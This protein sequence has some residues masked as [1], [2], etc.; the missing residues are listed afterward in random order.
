LRAEKGWTQEEA[1]HRCGMTT[2]HLQSVEGEDV[3]ATL[4][5]LARLSEGFEVD[6]AQLFQSRR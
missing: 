6:V 1:A 2:R 3:N 5:T 4:T